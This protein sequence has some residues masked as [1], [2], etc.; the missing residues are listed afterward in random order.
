MSQK[1]L[2]LQEREDFRFDQFP[3]FLPSCQTAAPYKWLLAAKGHDVPE[4]QGRHNRLFE[5]Q[6]N[7]TAKLRPRIRSHTFRRF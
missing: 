5:K 3:S 4:T 1:S 6:E 7:R 2:G